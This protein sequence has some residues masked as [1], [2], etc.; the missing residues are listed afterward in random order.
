MNYNQFLVWN[1]RGLNSRA[2]RTAVK[3]VI[4]LEQVSVVCLQ[5]T[6]V[7]AISQNMLVE[8]LGTDFDYS[9]LPSIGA[10]G[11]CSSPSV[12]NSGGAP[13][14]PSGHSRSRCAWN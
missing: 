5:E 12:G 4:V 11:V 3:D 13:A 1:A 2:R 7:A 9:L 6:K 10:A 14:M 8:L